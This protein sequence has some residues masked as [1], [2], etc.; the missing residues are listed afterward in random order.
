MD[1]QMKP[2]RSL[3]TARLGRPLALL[4]L[5]AG[6]ALA[7]PSLLA[8]DHDDKDHDRHHKA[9]ASAQWVEDLRQGRIRLEGDDA[10]VDMLILGRDIPIPYDYIATLMRTPNAF[11]QGAACIICHS[12]S[13]PAK[14]YRGLNLSTCEGIKAGSTEPPVRPI[15][16]PGQP[17]K[18]SILGRR[19]RNNRMPLGVHFSA[20]PND[21]NITTVFNWIQAGAKKDEHFKKEVQPLFKTDNAFAADTPSCTTCHL[22]NQ[23]PPSFHEL[24]LTSHEGIMLGADSVAKGVDKATATPVVIPGQPLESGLYQHL[25][26]DRMPPGIPPTADRDHP[27]TLIL[28]RWIEQGASCG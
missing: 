25:V 24:D 3:T 10:A 16:A 27:N 18:K 13:D 4:L 20:K 6:T 21:H 26:E 12:T 5:A 7:S 19:M 11:G 15:F 2:S 23:E 22:S 1:N 17:A 28:L 14:S 8:K 9:S